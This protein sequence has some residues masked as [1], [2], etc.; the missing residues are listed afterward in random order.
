M[1]FK[2]ALRPAQAIVNEHK[3][4]QNRSKQITQDDDDNP[5]PF[6]VQETKNYPKF[7]QHSQRLVDSQ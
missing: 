5:E 2:S 4:T 3:T 1:K 6:V 7:S